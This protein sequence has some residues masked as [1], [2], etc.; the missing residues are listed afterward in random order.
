MPS[1]ED[2]LAEALDR[3]RFLEKVAIAARKGNRQEA[4]KLE[5]ND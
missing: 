2:Q 4:T 3:A 5:K 1:H